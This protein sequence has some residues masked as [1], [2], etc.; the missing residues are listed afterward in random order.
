MGHGGFET[1]ERRRRVDAEVDLPPSRREKRLPPTLTSST[2]SPSRSLRGRKTKRS[3]W[4]RGATF[5]PS[6][7]HSA[8]ASPSPAAQKAGYRERSRAHDGPV[9]DP[10]DPES[11]RTAAMANAVRIA[12]PRS[13]RRQGRRAARKRLPGCDAR[14]AVTAALASRPRTAADRTAQA[15]RARRAAGRAPRSPRP[16][17][18]ALDRRLA[19][20]CDLRPFERLRSTANL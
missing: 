8:L 19:S 9:V 17:W 16:A 20:L 4:C 10:N 14:G 7:R 13:A 1:D 5:R 3:P 11:G 18:P 15:A 12:A 6:S 2:C